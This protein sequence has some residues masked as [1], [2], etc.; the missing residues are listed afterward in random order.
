MSDIE[1]RYST[2]RMS[3]VVC[4]AGVAYLCGQTAF[5]TNCPADVAGQVRE[6]LSRVDALLTEVGSDRG[7]IL[8]ATIHLK[9]I[10]D[11]SEMNVV[12][13]AWLRDGTA[14]AR[15]TVEARLASP[16][17]LF[18]VTVTAALNSPPA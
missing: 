6:T 14:P 3:K 11:F 5:G 7:R 2:S 10:D 8:S 13:E 9:S 18:E 12:W 17:L 1:R 15:T 4:H 16:E